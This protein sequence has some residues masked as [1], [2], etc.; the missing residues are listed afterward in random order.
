MNATRSDRA[1]DAERVPDLSLRERALDPTESFIVQAPAG[2]GKT[3]LLIQ[4]LLAL[5]ARVEAPERI[6]ALTFTRKAAA[7]MR[8]RLVAALR[9]ARAGAPPETA[10]E[11]RRIELAQTVLERDRALGWRLEQRPNAVAIE[12]FD[13]FALRLA[14]AGWTPSSVD[15]S[16]WMRLEEDLGALYR[17]AA[18]A[19]IEASEPPE[20][21]SATQALLRRFD[22]RVEAL[23]NNL[24]A[25][26]ER[27]ALWLRHALDVSESAEVLR[28]RLIVAAIEER[29]AWLE[30]RWTPEQFDVLRR[31]AA[32]W[33][34]SGADMPCPEPWLA[35][36]CV[37]PLP[38]ARFATLDA[39]RAV[40]GLTLAK[41]SA[42]W[43]RRPNL[44]AGAE[45]S[46][47]SGVKRLLEE[48]AAQ[49]PDGTHA[50]ALCA[51]VSY[52][53][54]EA[55]AEQR[56]VRSATAVLLKHALAELQ[57]LMAERGV[58]DY[59]QVSLAALQALE[60][61]Q[62]ALAERLDG[63]IDHLLV[64]EFQDTNPAQRD[65]LRALVAEWSPGDGRT[66]FAVGDPMQSIYAFRDADVGIF[67]EVRDRGLGPVRPTPLVLSA[68]FRARAPLVEWVNATFAG[69]FAVAAKR[70]PHAPSVGFASAVATRAADPQAGIEIRRFAS[71]QAEAEWIAESIEALQ[72]RAPEARIAV[73]VRR[74]QDA[75]PVLSAL[76]RRDV[77]TS[78]LEFVPLAQRPLVQELWAAACLLAHP[79]DRLALATWLRS[80]MVG[81]RLATLEVVLDWL[82][83]S[84]PESVLAE[85]AQWPWPELP[86]EERARLERA[87][88]ALVEAR[89]L[90]TA[91][92]LAER[93][94]RLFLELGGRRLAQ[95]E[96]E[97][98][99]LEAFFALLEE[100]SAEGLLRDRAEFERRLAQRMCTLNP[101]RAEARG[102]AV[103][104]L[105]IHKA[106]GLE[107]DVVYVPALDQ[108]IKSDDSAQM[109]W[110]FF[111]DRAEPRNGSQLIAATRER[112]HSEASAS[113]YS[114]VRTAAAQVRD[115][116]RARLLYVAATRA[117]ERLVLS[118]HAAKTVPSS[119]LAALLDWPPPAADPEAREM[120]PGE[121][122]APSTRTLA[123]LRV[124]SLLRSA[125]PWPRRASASCG[126]GAV[127]SEPSAQTLG[128][129]EMPPED[130]SAS[131]QQASARAVGVVGHRLL[132]SLGRL[133][134]R[135]V[136]EVSFEAHAIA[137]WLERE[138]APR[139]AVEAAAARL[140]EHCTRLARDSQTLAWLFDPS[141]RMS[142]SEVTLAVGETTLRP[143]RTFVT[144]TGE[145]WIVDYKFAEPPPGSSV[146]GW[147]AEERERHR[148]QLQRYAS[149]LGH[150]RVPWRAAL[151]FVWL[152]RRV[153]L[154]LSLRAPA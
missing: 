77:I 106:K 53:D 51:V 47:Q 125:T 55:L 127:L 114:F 113:V 29:L 33:L 34:S 100:A 37:G 146:E 14:R 27:R 28:D 40:A 17:E 145:R 56:E 13:A 65:L 23:V 128:E 69:V 75:W 57:L 149:S 43:R 38:G 5:L 105:T 148:A 11:Q 93:L 117:R 70:C 118:G 141:H 10:H 22:N 9:A 111:R 130:Q 48:L 107:W 94:W 140:A 60:T 64:D 98:E 87:L 102:R 7:E 142:H 61:N 88:E 15:R 96:A 68:N 83:E 89:A 52:P 143:D 99:E 41:N 103:E 91:R 44:P 82:A 121:A 59:A 26:L 123:P 63:R 67:L 150:P 49:D 20:R 153:E 80:P 138:G 71:A 101:A 97:R 120:S 84:S 129:V 95:G 6:L 79:G 126:T 19:A 42:D 116:E 32:C 2:A 131:P 154:E 112:R 136:R 110:A 76:A 133:L 31:A 21:L 92:S 25:L 137:R 109:V 35:A 72:A 90:H 144:V 108:A 135:G 86:E 119:S 115:A 85:R 36:L 152:D 74:R 151:Y 81:L 8:E 16:P 78:A 50:A 104:V 18:R 4:R 66:F 3:E 147:L 12:T 46:L 24:A 124:P 132:E 73:L 45:T 39:W 54:T 134:E 1:G 30:A 139:E 62:A 58:T 122:T